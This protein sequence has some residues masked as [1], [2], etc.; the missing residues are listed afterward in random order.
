MTT[1]HERESLPWRT[2]RT[3]RRRAIERV[4]FAA[5]RIPDDKGKFETN[6]GDDLINEALKS[7][8]KAKAAV[9]GVDVAL[10]PEAATPA[11][12]KASAAEPPATVSSAA[13]KPEPVK[14][15]AAEELATLRQQLEFSMAKGR[16][17]MDR[18]KD[19]HEK[20]LRA[21][22]DLENFKK[23][24]AKEKEEVL[25]FGSERLLRDFLPVID[26]F[27][28]A[29]EH[30]RS[31][32]D[33]ESLRKGVEMIRKLFEDSLGKHGVKSFTATGQLF[34]PNRHE[35]MSA[36]ETNALPP[37]HVHHEVL[38]GFT[39][40]ERLVRPALVVVTRPL[41]VAEAA[42]PE[43]EPAGS[44]EP[45]VSAVATVATAGSS[46]ESSPS[47]QPESSPASNEPSTP[48]T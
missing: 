19:E 32:A 5:V 40:N 10:E 7:V 28:R 37:N 38:R 24:A 17:L 48:S 6:I 8:D 36:V 39:L 21:V 30:A 15:E 34:D 12:A 16:E 1:N 22:A 33:Y 47:V 23:R 31:A 42:A 13:V 4:Q 29:L 35:A 14:N 2:L 25:K 26:N 46:S 41:P 27:D 11:A 9:Q 44:A 43:T 20:M 45:A 3:P 18:V